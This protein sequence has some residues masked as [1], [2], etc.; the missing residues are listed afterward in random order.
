[1]SLNVG[2]SG[3]PSG[4]FPGKFS[5]YHLLFSCKYSHNHF[6]K[7]T[8]KKMKQEEKSEVK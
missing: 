8:V 5:F 4:E 7:K 6:S 1:M 3:I 2:F